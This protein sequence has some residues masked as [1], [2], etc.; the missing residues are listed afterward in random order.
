MAVAARRK[1]TPTRAVADRAAAQVPAANGIRLNDEKPGLAPGFSLRVSRQLSTE[2]D[3]AR[4][5]LKRDEIGM[6]RHGA[7]LSEH[8]LFGKPLHT[9]LDQALAPWP[10][11]FQ[12]VPARRAHDARMNAAHGSALELGL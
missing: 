12:R 10:P 5:R 3:V 8:D 2:A 4:K 6:N 7:F 11:P 9:F 1:S